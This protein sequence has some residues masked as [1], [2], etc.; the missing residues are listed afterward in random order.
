MTLQ[1]ILDFIASPIGIIV[2][3]GLIVSAC[4][5]IFSSINQ[6]TLKDY[7]A[8][9][10]AK[11]EIIDDL[12]YKLDDALE[13]IDLMQSTINA[14]AKIIEEL[15]Q[16]VAEMSGY[17]QLDKTLKDAVLAIHTKIDSSKKEILSAIK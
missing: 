13:K 1:I 3:V 6:Q 9:V 10:S 4:V 8:S 15:R 17:T 12:K 7:Q 11:N 5:Y 2:S 16:Q 14:Q